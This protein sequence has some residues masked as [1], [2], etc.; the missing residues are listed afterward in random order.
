MSL[1]RLGLQAAA[2]SSS[3]MRVS[4]THMRGTGCAIRDE[5]LGKPTSANT[6]D[7]C[8]YHP[9]MSQRQRQGSQVVVG[10]VAVSCIRTGKARAAQLVDLYLAHRTPAWCLVG[11]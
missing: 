1:L 6:T 5:K 9:P 2:T 7:V 3:E 4:S 10:G 11:L 8:I